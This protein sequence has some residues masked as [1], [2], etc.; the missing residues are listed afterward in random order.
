MLDMVLGIPPDKCR[1][2]LYIII[3]TDSGNLVQYGCR[4]KN[5]CK[6]KTH[7]DWKKHNEQKK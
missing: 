4:H 7:E 5:G 6:R 1:E 2:C 3:S